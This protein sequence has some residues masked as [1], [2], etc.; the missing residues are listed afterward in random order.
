MTAFNINENRKELLWQ[1]TYLTMWSC[2]R[3]DKTAFEEKFTPYATLHKEGIGPGVHLQ[4]ELL[5]LE[6]K[7]Q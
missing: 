2:I 6:K 4:K 5:R 7:N 3:L 1:L